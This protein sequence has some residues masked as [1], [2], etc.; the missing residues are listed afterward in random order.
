MGGTGQRQQTPRAQ[1]Q[2]EAI[3][4]FLDP[5]RGGYSWRE[6]HTDV[7]RLAGIL[8]QIMEVR[9]CHRRRN[10]PFSGMTL[11]W[12]M[13]QRDIWA[14]FKSQ[15]GASW[16]CIWSPRA[17]RNPGARGGGWESSH[18]PEPGIHVP[19]QCVSLDKL[20]A[21]PSEE[22]L[23]SRALE[24]LGERRLWA[25]IVFLS[26]EHPLDPSKLSSPALGPGHLRFKIRMDIDDVTRTN[27]IRDR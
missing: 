23:V 8:G 4:D 18:T 21:V 14:L 20:E 1:K 25:G 24:L 16:P 2:L 27:K 5:S 15:E 19:P 9:H 7:G 10:E 13:E 22:A 3:R 6:A 11:S 12:R 17:M 26:P